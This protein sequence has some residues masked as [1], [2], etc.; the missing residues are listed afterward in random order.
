MDVTFIQTAQGQ[1][2][3]EMLDATSRTV[4]EF[5]NRHG[6]DY[7]IFV[8]LKRG[9]HSW[10][11]SFNRIPMLQEL[12]DKGY[13]GWAIYLDADAYIHDLDF[14]LEAYLADK[15]ERAGVM[16]S[17]GVEPKW[18][19]NSG[20]VLLN[21]GHAHGREIVE[22]WNARLDMLSDGELA[23]MVDWP[24]E[25]NDQTMLFDVLHR[26]RH[27][28]GA[29]HYESGELINHP[30]ARFIR[31]VLRAFYPDLSV[32]VNAIRTAVDEIVPVRGDDV[33]ERMY[34]VAMSALYR[35]V[36]GRDPEST[37]LEH[38]RSR[39]QQKGMETAFR[40][41]L[42]EF[43]ASGEFQGR[44]K[45]LRA[46]EVTPARVRAAYKW[47][48]GREADD[49]GVATYTNLLESGELDLD[50]LR[51]ILLTSEEFARSL[52]QYRIVDMDHGIK[53]VV[54]PTEP[55]FG[56]AIA[57]SG[58]WEPHIV[59]AIRSNLKAGDTFVDIGGNVGIMSFN[60][61]DVVG[62][63]G[64]VIAFE[65]NP[66]NIAAYRRGIAANGFEHV[67]L[68]SFAVS[69][70]R[71]MLSVTSVSNSKVSGEATPTQA[72]DVIQA[73]TA[74]EILANETRVDFIKIDIEGWELPALQGSLG[75]LRRHKP[76]VLC[77]FNPL[78]LNA[79]GGIDAS[80]LA[81]F[82]FDLTSSVELVEH[83]MS[84]TKVYSAPELMELWHSRD[85]EATSAGRLPAGWVHFDL[86]FQVQ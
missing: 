27:L 58:T 20:V 53:V 50:G 25:L 63:G 55:D 22:K 34:P 11:A 16:L 47:I 69:D 79:Q 3:K 12:V 60:A 5:C 67:T 75:T 9:V 31:Q 40:E 65:P 85:A 41:T 62:P 23:E 86:L 81:N 72:T 19:V 14:D 77:E 32:R 76:M 17:V 8:G 52:V 36:L 35:S 73:V 59:D 78:C 61:A 54:D 13:R 43:M 18:D 24:L 29:I 6:H 37:A 64:K 66:R 46:H 4:I 2:Y 84:R 48:L 39:F 26:N 83:N 42:E 80:T 1:A 45:K 68:Y 56:K 7:E 44:Q 33:V 70:R 82:I 74:D 71:S 28:R 15:S 51:N 10:Q 38:F 49:G 57:G 21:L 30:Y